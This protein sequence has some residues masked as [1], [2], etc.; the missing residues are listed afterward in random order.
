MKLS[1]QIVHQWVNKEMW[2]H[3][4]ISKNLPSKEYEHNVFQEENDTRCATYVFSN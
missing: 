4:I 1:I 2:L 3:P